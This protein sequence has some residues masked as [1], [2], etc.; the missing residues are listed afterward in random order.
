MLSTTADDYMAGNTMFNGDLNKM[1][2][3][4]RYFCTV[5][6]D[7]VNCYTFEVSIY[8]YQLKKEERT[9]PYTEESCIFMLVD[10]V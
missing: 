5:L 6:G 1:G 2:T 4:R 7:Q 9:V 8:G 3:A 10:Y